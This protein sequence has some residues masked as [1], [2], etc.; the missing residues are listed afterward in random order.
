MRLRGLAA[1]CLLLAGCATA[2][3]DFEQ[4]FETAAV[5]GPPHDAWML[6]LDMRYGCDTV[7]VKANA[8]SWPPRV[9]LPELS[10]G[11]PRLTLQT[12]LSACDLATLIAPEIVRAWHTPPGLREEWQ[13]RT[14][15]G[16]LST[17]FLEGPTQRELRVKTVAR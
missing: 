7:L 13:Y 8:P 6:A 3:P 14:R 9:G 4:R 15:G 2:H 12:G 16:L 5:T 11:V 1:C 17:V 10:R